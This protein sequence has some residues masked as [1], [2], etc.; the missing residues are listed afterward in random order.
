MKLTKV[1]FDGILECGAYIKGADVEVR[2]DY[3]MNELVRAI[4]A[5]GYKAFM[6]ENMRVLVKV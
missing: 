4:K 2:E 3:G 1:Y 5:A 6:T